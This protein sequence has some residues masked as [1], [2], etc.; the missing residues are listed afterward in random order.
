MASGCAVFAALLALVCCSLLWRWL[1]VCACSF[2]SVISRLT[3]SYPLVPSAHLPACLCPPPAARGL[4]REREGRLAGLNLKAMALPPGRGGGTQQAQAAL[5]REYL[6]WERGNPQQLDEATYAARWAHLRRR[7]GPGCVAPGGGGGD[8][9]MTTVPSHAE[10]E[11]S[12]V[13][14]I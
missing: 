7:V 11:F 3:W 9:A 6:E 10:F 12:S 13:W 4:L 5:W 14:S 2:S 8:G 1:H